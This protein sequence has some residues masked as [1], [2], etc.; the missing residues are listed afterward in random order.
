MLGDFNKDLL[1]TNQ[2]RDWVNSM[3]SLGFTQLVN[4]PTRVTYSTSTL[5]DHIYTTNEENI[6]DAR[7]AQIGL[8]DH[9]AIFC[10][11]KI[12]FSLKNNSHKT[13]KYRSFKSFNEN[14]FLQ[15]LS[16][17]PWSEI[18]LLENVDTML[19]VWYDFFN[20]VIDKHAPIKTHR[21]KNEVQPEWVTSDIL[22]RIKQRDILK[23]EGRFD[24][25]R[26][27]RNEVSSII[28]EAKGSVY[29]TKIEEGKNDPKT[30]W[31]LSKEFGVNNKTSDENS[32][33]KIKS[34][35]DIISDEFDLAERFNDFFINIATNLKEPI[36]ESNFDDLQEYI[37]QKIPDNVIFELPEIDENFVFMY[38]STL[39]VSKATGLDG[40][41]PKMLKLSSGIIT[42]R[43]TYIVNKCILYGHFPDSWK[44]AKVNPLFKSSAK[45][46][47]NSYR[48]IP[49]LPTLSKL[50]E[51][52][53]Q[54]HL[55]NYLNTFDVLHK[56][57]SVFRSGHST[58]TALTLM[59][60]RWLKAINDGNIV[61]TIMMI[62]EK[63]LIL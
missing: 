26:I 46:D 55:M 6:S 28:Q 20:D 13:I 61:G 2:T 30:I 54:K 32:C 11:R 45:D 63:R 36:K 39:D 52:F 56:F 19:G 35:D 21:I 14:E 1:K 10:C 9:Y 17:V 29:K 25:Y 33:L 3:K 23:K 34:G 62:L 49:I 57:Q 48:P 8:S 51:K 42:K 37:R 18:E 41:G 44:Q 12:N 31:K 43:F 27:A 24:D 40:I 16:A 47:I 22:D 58:E 38:L 53:M 7:V 60:E 59:T 50:I 5:I 4:C 15:D